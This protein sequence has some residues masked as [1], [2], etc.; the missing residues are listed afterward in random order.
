MD[1][2]TKTTSKLLQ[3]TID[4][5]SSPKLMIFNNS[6]EIFS[7]KTQNL[8]ISTLSKQANRPQV[9]SKGKGLKKIMETR[10]IKQ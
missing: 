10:K 4:K 8:S 1:N 2:K 5:I 3:R 9:F 7:Q 6:A